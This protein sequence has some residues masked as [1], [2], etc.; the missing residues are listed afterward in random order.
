MGYANPVVAGSSPA[1]GIYEGREVTK[2]S[3]AVLVTI[4]IAGDEMWPRLEMR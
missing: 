3:A 4:E 2:A 1:W